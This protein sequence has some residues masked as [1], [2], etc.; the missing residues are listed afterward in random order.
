MSVAEF[1]PKSDPLP[2]PAGTSAKG[3]RLSDPALPSVLTLS[4]SPAALVHM[5][6]QIQSSG[7]NYIRLGV[8][9]SGCNGY[10]YTLD[11][12]DAPEAE[13]RLI[14]LQVA[15]APM[16]E[17]VDPINLVVANTDLS[18]VNETEIDLVVEGLN[19]ALRFK[20]PNAQSHCGCGESFSIAA[21][22]T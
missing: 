18:L 19:S 17:P 12:V 13:D 7:Q 10:M 16:Q 20:N 8:K 15:A 6:K 21:T 5:H 14:Q 9:E 1:D 3:E 2:Q 22:G 4:A 11:F